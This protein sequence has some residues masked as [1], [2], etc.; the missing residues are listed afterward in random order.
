MQLN[1]FR[2]TR[3]RYSK[4]SHYFEIKYV[5]I[6]KIWVVKFQVFNFKKIDLTRFLSDFNFPG[7]KIVVYVLFR[8][9]YK[10]KIKKSYRPVYDVVTHSNKITGP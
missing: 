8:T 5:K 10:L 3:S 6:T 1:A 4:A 7:L 2:V 9:K